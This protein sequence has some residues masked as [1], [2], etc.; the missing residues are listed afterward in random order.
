MRD[1]H[2]EIDLPCWLEPLGAVEVLQ[3]TLRGQANPEAGVLGLCLRDRLLHQRPAQRVQ[4]LR[5][6]TPPTFARQVLV[7][8]LPD[9]AQAHAE[10]RAAARHV[11]QA[12]GGHGAVREF[13]DLLLV[14]SGQYARLLEAYR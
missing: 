14:A 10:V 9:F 4:R 1:A 8:Q 2:I 11:T 6:T 3:V 5:V 7:P 13:C 12:A